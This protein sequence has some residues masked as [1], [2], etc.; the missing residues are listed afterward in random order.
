MAVILIAS[1]ERKQQK[2]YLMIQRET[3]KYFKEYYNM[4]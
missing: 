4:S 2:K 3:S 1:G